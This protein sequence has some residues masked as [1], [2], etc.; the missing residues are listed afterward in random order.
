MS[1][2][3]FYGSNV[4]IFLNNGSKIQGIITNFD[5]QSLVL[6]LKSRQNVIP[7]MTSQIKDLRIIPN[8]QPVSKPSTPRSSKARLR[9]AD[10]AWNTAD[11]NDDFDF[12]AN[13]EK[14]N[15][16]KLFAEFRE[17][18]KSDPAKLLVSHNKN[19]QRNYSP[20]Q[21]VLDS[22]SS[23]KEESPKK[24]GP[25]NPLAANQQKTKKSPK[26]SNSETITKSKT[27]DSSR[28]ASVELKTSTGETV[29]SVDKD[30]I[31][32]GVSESILNTNSEIVVEGAAQLISQLVHSFLG[33]SR[34]L[35]KLNHNPS[36]VVCLLVG[37]HDHASA[38]VA[39]GRRLASVG[40][41]VVLRCTQ[42]NNI[43]GKQ[44][45]MFESAGGLVPSDDE[46][47]KCLESLSTPV[48]LIVDSLSGLRPYDSRYNPLVKWANQNRAPI[49]SLDYPSGLDESKTLSMNAKWTLAF[50]AVSNDLANA[51]LNKTANDTIFLGNLGTGFHVWEQLGAGQSQADGE[52]LTQLSI[53]D[54]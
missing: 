39:A 35:G 37:K 54:K 19:T 21:N 13:L 9:E 32:R 17:R 31:I 53:S 51:A 24:P 44:L 2:A 29:V 52:W 38:A 23:S 26:S 7:V 27:S 48:E 40:I 30:I 36:P 12:A 5:P 10:K 45:L 18:D 46:F 15:K 49:L 4:E 8:E 47:G 25:K 22:V 42:L 33:G 50:G 20:T 41:T 11:C 1:V 6:Q 14:F 43:D 34:R 28:N 3:D 16:Q